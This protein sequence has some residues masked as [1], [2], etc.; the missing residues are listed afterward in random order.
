ML[1]HGHHQEAHVGGLPSE[2]RV[3][4]VEF[5]GRDCEE[6]L[7]VDPTVLSCPQRLH[8]SLFQQYRGGTS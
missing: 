5:M 2:G 8:W 6:S 1:L 7:R 3:L 4:M